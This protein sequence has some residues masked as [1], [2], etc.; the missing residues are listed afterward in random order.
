VCEQSGAHSEYEWLKH[1]LG[2]G[3]F[4]DNDIEKLEIAS[5]RFCLKLNRVIATDCDLAA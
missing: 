2:S 3:E 1:L 5:K 4:S